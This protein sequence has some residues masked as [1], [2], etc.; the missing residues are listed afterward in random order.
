[1]DGCYA[2]DKELEYVSAVPEPFWVRRSW[3]FFWQS[4]PSCYT[5]RIKFK[6]RQDWNMHYVLKHLELRKRG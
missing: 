2:F 6:D 1:M 3:F 5:C 4:V